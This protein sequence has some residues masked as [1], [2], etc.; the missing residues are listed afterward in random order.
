MRK[1]LISAVEAIV[2]QEEEAAIKVYPLFNSPYEG[3]A[4]ILEEFEEAKEDM[5]RVESFV[6]ELWCNVRR[7]VF[8]DSRVENC[9]IV[10]IEA[11]NEVAI[12]LACEAIQIAAM[13]NKF[14]ESTRNHRLI[15]SDSVLDPRD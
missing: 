12:K 8:N 7:N 5:D 13:A 9:A 4:V 10:D 14:I 15:E 11:L 3:Y 2:Q 1:E 6:A